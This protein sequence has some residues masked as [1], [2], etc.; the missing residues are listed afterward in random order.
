LFVNR[1]TFAAALLSFAVNTPAM[2]RDA[3]TKFTHEGV[4][5]TYTVTT[6]GD[7][8]RIIEGTATPGSPFRL[9]VSGDR[10]SGKANGIPVSFYVKPAKTAKT[11]TVTV[12]SR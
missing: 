1:F 8:T 3:A 6:V 10:V 9:V 2:A 7:D 12:A 4:S 11:P 5:Y